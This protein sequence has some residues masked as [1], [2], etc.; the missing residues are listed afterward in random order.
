MHQVDAVAN[1]PFK[2]IR[3]YRNGFLSNSWLPKITY[4]KLHYLFQRE[5]ISPC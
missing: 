2:E 3:P 4:Q 1:M 5:M